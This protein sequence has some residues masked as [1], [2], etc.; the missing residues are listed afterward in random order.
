MVSVGRNLVEFIL[1]N[2][3][4]S[5][6]NEISSHYI[7]DKSFHVDRRS[8]HG[9]DIVIK[10]ELED[11]FINAYAQQVQIGGKLCVFE[12]PG[13]RFKEFVVINTSSV[14]E[15]TIKLMIKS[16]NSVLREFFPFIEIEQLKSSVS[17]SKNIQKSNSSESEFL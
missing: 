5:N 15:T 3:L 6:G 7:R 9:G 12:Q 1:S 17:L 16:V 10:P 2:R 13:D 4:A 8:S 11:A 14:T